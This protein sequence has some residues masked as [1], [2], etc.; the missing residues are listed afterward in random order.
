MQNNSNNASGQ[1]DAPAE[2]IELQ[3]NSR[4]NDKLLSSKNTGSKR[5]RITDQMVDPDL[6][7]AEIAK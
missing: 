7:T 6:T 3:G 5:A 1:G 4:E 2:G